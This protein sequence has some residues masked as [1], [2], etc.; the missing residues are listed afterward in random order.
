MKYTLYIGLLA[1]IALMIG[2]TPI[3]NTSDN[4]SN[5]V[6]EK[7]YVSTDT[8]ECMLIKFM[9][10]EGY[11]PFFDDMGCGCTKQLTNYTQEPVDILTQS[12]LI[13]EQLRQQESTVVTT[14]QNQSLQNPQPPCHIAR[15]V[16]TNKEI[17]LVEGFAACTMDYQVVDIC[18]QFSNF[19]N[20]TLQ[21]TDTFYSCVQQIQAL[22]TPTKQVV[23]ACEQRSQ[24]CT[25]EYRPVCGVDT[26]GNIQTFGNA[27]TAC[28]NTSIQ[29]YW[30]GEC[31]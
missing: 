18:T 12:E 4:Q 9:C 17:T 20:N 10:E 26:Q 28:A 15:L 8:N 31:N 16:A 27:C 7:L 11:Q 6:T 1:I 30:E 24:M 14:V 29:E 25:K 19:T 22:E 23:Y 5:N 13:A 3:T 2:C 21:L